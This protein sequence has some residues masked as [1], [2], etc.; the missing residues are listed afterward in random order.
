M[1]GKHGR[2]W[3]LAAVVWGTAWSGQAEEARLLPF[4]KALAGDAAL[5]LP[6]GLTVTLHKQDQDYRLKSLDVNIPLLDAALLGNLS[7]KNETGEA[8]L[9][10][11][12][13][14]LPFLNVFGLVGRIDGET[15]VAVPP[16]IADLTIDYEGIVYGAG[17]TVAGG[18]GRY[19]ASF[20]AL[21]T[22]TSLR[23]SDS[24]VTAWVLSPR[25]GRTFTTRRDRALTCW[26][27]AMY[28]RADERHAGT[29]ELPGFGPVRY[30]VVLEDDD[31]WNVTLGAATDIHEQL[32]IE[33]EVGAGGRSQATGSLVW[34]F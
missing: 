14:L 9:K 16:V 32:S 15:E 3:L 28:Q 13:W 18:I 4:G 23:E 10:L 31:P 33:L 19:F 27:G 24:A 29:I 17:L 12:V 8:N 11:D 25:V 7:V 22:D 34:R 30:D 6:Y 26:L 20:T 2:P 1:F 5:P 21:Y